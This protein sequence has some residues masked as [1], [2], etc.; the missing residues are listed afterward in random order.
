MGVA[1]YVNTFV[2]QYEGAGRP[3]RIGPIVWQ[4]MWIGIFAA[5]LMLATTRWSPLLLAWANQ[6][7][8]LARLEATFYRVL[9]FGSGAMI[10]AAAQVSFHVLSGMYDFAEAWVVELL[11]VLQYCDQ[12]VASLKS[13]PPT[14]TLKGVEASPLTAKPNCATA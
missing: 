13:V 5:P 12:V 7:P 1:L 3:Q 14:A 2:A 9:T 8:E 6:E 10:I 4:G 11:V